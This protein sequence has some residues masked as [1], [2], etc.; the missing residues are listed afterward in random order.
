MPQSRLA[1]TDLPMREIL[2]NGATLVVK[3]SH[4]TP[5]VAVCALAPGGVR[6]ETE[7]NNGITHLVQRTL[8]KGTRR[9]TGAELADTLEYLGISLSPFTAKDFVGCSMLTLSRH[10]EQALALMAEILWQPAFDEDAVQREK[11]NIVLEIERKQDDIL[12]YSLDLCDGVLFPRHP[13]RLPLPGTPSSL[14]GLTSTEVRAWHEQLYRQTD[15]LIVCVVGDV[16]AEALAPRLEDLVPR[17]T[18]DVGTPW[19]HGTLG[20]P[21]RVEVQR[22]KRQAALTLGFQAPGLRSPDLPAFDVLSHLLSGMGS[23][24]FLEL[25]DRQGLAYVVNAQ[26]DP[27]LDAGSFRCYMATRPE[28]RQQAL[29]GLR[30]ELGRLRDE[31]VPPDEL[32]RTIQYMTG[33]HEISL[34][35][36][37]AQASRYAWYEATEL[38]YERVDRYPEEIARVTA[39]DVQRCARQYLCDERSALAEIYP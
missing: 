15:R 11:R 16:E 20:E 10:L 17:Q 6:Q 14:A 36:N 34:Q 30:Q 21:G 37:G 9:Q 31:P 4:A 28:A 23:R 3:E 26:Y 38:G 5:L 19:S 32:A 33:L 27:R 8:L 7:D 18:T 29:A 25:R 2:R 35:R 22:P 12:N 24:L 13:Y 1:G 39:E